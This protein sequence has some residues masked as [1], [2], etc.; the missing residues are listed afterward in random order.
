MDCRRVAVR[1]SAIAEDG[2]GASW[3]GQLDTSLNV[4]M[5]SLEDAIRNCWASIDAPHVALYLSDKKL[6]GEA[7]LVGVAVQVMVE[8]E[9]SGV[10]FT[11]DPVDGDKDIVLIEGIYG[12]GELLVQGE[13]TPDSYKYSKQLD[14]VV[15]FNINIQAKEMLFDGRQN[16]I[17]D[18]P[19]SKGDKA[20]LREEKIVELAKL[21]LK[22]ERHYGWPQDIEWA[23]R[24]ER[25]YLLQSRPITTL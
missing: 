8:S 7:K 9:V 3:A 22:V 4:D 18:L 2:G 1:S 16:R 13:V 5:A 20:V 10:M 6:S 17:V 21:G 19:E 12:L 25:F 23:L 11:V 24:G 14:Q 15:D